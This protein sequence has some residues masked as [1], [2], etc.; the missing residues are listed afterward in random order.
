M[1]T[2]RQIKLLS[3]VSSYNCKSLCCFFSSILVPLVTDLFSSVNNPTIGKFK[4]KRQ[5]IEPN[6]IT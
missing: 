6:I 5:R 2:N 4:V 3:I 1:W